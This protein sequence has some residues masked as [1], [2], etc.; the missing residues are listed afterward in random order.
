MHAA[1]LLLAATVGAGPLNVAVLYFE[2]H[3][4]DPDYDVLRKGLADIVA[5][6]LGNVPPIQIMERE[7]LE[8]LLQEQ[9]LQRTKAFDQTTAVRL[10]RLVGAS[11]TVSGALTALE[12][13]VVLTA[14]LTEVSTGKTLVN[15]KVTGKPED[16]LSMEQELIRKFAAAL[17]AK[18]EGEAPT[19]GRI[20]VSGLLAYSQ[21]LDLVDQ[22]ELKAAQSKLAEAVRVAPECDRAKATYALILRRVREAQ[23]RRGA[24]QGKDEAALE[25]SEEWGRKSLASLKSPEEVSRYFAYRAAKANLALLRMSR[26]LGVPEK[27]DSVQ[28]LPKRPEE[29]VVVYVPPSKRAA[30]AKLEATLVEAAERLAAD[31]REYRKR[32]R[33][34]TITFEFSEEDRQHSDALCGEDLGE[35][36]FATAATVAGAIAGY[37]VTGETPYWSNLPDFTVRPP[38]S[39]RDPTLQKQAEALFDKAM[40]EIPLDYEGDEVEARSLEILLARGDGLVLRGKREEGIAYFQ[41]FLDRFPKAEK[42]QLVSGRIETA[43]MASEE[44]EL[45][46]KALE[47]CAAPDA[48]R[49][50]E[51][52]TRL[53]RAEG[54]K[55]A[56]GLV[57]RLSAC[58]KKTKVYEPLVYAIPAGAAMDLGDCPTFLSL[59]AAAKKVGA[60]IGERPHQC[61]E[62]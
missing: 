4:N 61:D 27:K 2:N 58:A 29:K 60:P 10:G 6:D 23:K 34:Q 5:T 18:L 11:H 54:G 50:L 57:A 42:F 36:D 21:G 17:Q 49:L 25:K 13:A 51:Y 12:P 33:A 44:I 43:L 7:K 55:S 41:L 35:W 26:L 1:S 22:G 20:G 52:A 56:D 48:K 31:L 62:P 38:A 28:I 14:H 40:A 8:A 59:R 24:E 3:T 30:L 47:E 15:Q 32:G 45:D 19:A 9:K 16:L 53:L 39:W 37:L 46:R